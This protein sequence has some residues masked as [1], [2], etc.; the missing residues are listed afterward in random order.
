MSERITVIAYDASLT[1]TVAAGVVTYSCGEASGLDA[2]DAAQH[3]GHWYDLN[4]DQ[5]RRMINMVNAS[6]AIANLA[7]LA[8]GR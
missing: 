5:Q 6:I 7:N 3:L 1:G 2:T 4:P 8:P